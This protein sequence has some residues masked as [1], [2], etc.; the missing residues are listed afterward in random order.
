MVAKGEYVERYAIGQRLGVPWLAHTCGYCR[1]CMSGRENLCDNALFT[2]YT[3][4]GGYAEYAVADQHYCLALPDG[5]S[6]AEVA[7]LLCAELIGYWALVVAGIAERIGIYSFGPAAHI[8]AQVARWQGRNVFA[9]T[10]PGD[11]E[12]QRFAGKLGAAWT[13]DSTATPPEEMD[14]AILFAPVGALIPEALGHSAKGGTIACAG[15][16]MSDTPG[17]L[18]GSVQFAPLPILRAVTARNVLKSSP[19]S[20]SE[21]RWKCSGWKKQTRLL[22]VCAMAKYAAQPCW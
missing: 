6:D 3:L 16:H 22:L 21:P 14:A 15:I 9:F 12:G 8:I 19:R 17:I 4:N 7:P 13:G 20:G 11:L 10:K 18:W 2:G 5:Y 1:Y